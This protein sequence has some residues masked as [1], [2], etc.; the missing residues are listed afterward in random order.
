MFGFLKKKQDKKPKPTP[1]A[2]PTPLE[3]G[4]K[5]FQLHVDGMP[6]PQEKNNHRIGR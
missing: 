2:K 6:R 3:V 1:E 5:I 4:A